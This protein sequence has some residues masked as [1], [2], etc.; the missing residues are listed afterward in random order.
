[1]GTIIYSSSLKVNNEL[2]SRL[3]NAIRIIERGSVL[4][5]DGNK[6][7]ERVVAIFPSKDKN[8]PLYTVLWTNEDIL[9][10]LNSLSLQHVLMLEKELNEMYQ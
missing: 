7:G 4:D 9:N 6:K 5:K 3:K 10:T 1:L 2:K 8:I